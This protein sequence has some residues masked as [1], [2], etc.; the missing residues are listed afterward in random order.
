MLFKNSVRTSKRTPHFTITRINWLMLFK[1]NKASNYLALCKIPVICSFATW[2]KP[3]PVNT[4]RCVDWMNQ[5]ICYTRIVVHVN[6]VR[7]CLWT[8][9]ASGPIVRPQVIYEHGEPRWNDIDRVKPKN[10]GKTCPSAT[11]FTTNSTWSDQ[12]ANPAS[13]LRGRR[14]TAWA[15]APYVNYYTDYV[16][17]VWTTYGTK[18]WAECV[19]LKTIVL[20]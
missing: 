12:A 16:P 2:F 18:L 7:L 4:N 20:G 17:N 19:C 11:L 13:A 5:L 9:S 8:A 6:V 1:F 10:S 3:S 14:L 15:M